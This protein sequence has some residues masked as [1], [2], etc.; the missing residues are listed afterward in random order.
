V[1]L[2][3]NSISQGTRTSTSNIFTWAISLA[4]GTNNVQAIGTKGGT[5]VTDSLVWI[6]AT[7]PPPP[8]P[9]PGLLS[10]G[11]PVTVSSFQAG[12]VATNGN[13]GNLSTRW[14]ASDGTY[15]QWWR[16]D[17]GSTQSITQAIINWYN[18]SARAYQYKIETSNNDATYSTLVDKTGNTSFGDTTNTFS[19]TTRYVRITV[20]GC[21]GCG[22][23]ASFYECQIFGP[24]ST[25]PSAPT[26]LVATAGDTVVNLTWVQSASPGITTNKVYR[27][28]TGSGGP[29]G[30]LASLAAT[31]SYSDTAVVNGSNYFYTVTAVSSNGESAMSGSAGATPLSAFQS[32][33][34]AYFGCW[35]RPQADPA[36]DPDGDGMSNTNEF[37]AGFDPTNPAAYPHI[38]GIAVTN[39]TDVA[40]SYLASN[41]NTNYPGGPMTRTNVLDCATG[42]ADSSYANNFASAGLTNILS[43]GTGLGTNV[44]VIESFGATNSARY[45]RVRVLV[46]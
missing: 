37:L 10:Q 23:F 11:Q 9:P 33:Q 40:I 38:T 28:T 12:N 27:S 8:P 25:P 6:L 14:A 43:G 15:P 45:Y 44:T 22:G 13:D 46:P 7:P 5:N 34:M 41:G 39:G 24:V 2:F 21:N 18:S 20:T 19:A 29:Y 30:L 32:W 16:V 3:L 26:S 4:G 17:L 35:A 31:T 1:E 36:A 42:T